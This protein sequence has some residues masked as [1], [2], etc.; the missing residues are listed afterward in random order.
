[1]KILEFG[2]GMGRL[3]KNLADYH[4]SEN[5]YGTDISPT[6]I[7]HSQNHLSGTNV[8]TSVINKDGS[9]PY[10]DEQ[11]DRI[12]SYA[13][14]QHISKK[15]VVQKSIAEISRTLKVGG[16]VKI[17]FWMISNPFFERRLNTD[18][19]AFE[20]KSLI[21]GWTTKFTVPLYRISFWRSNE[22]GGIR[23]GYRQLIKEFQ[24]NKIEIYGITREYPQFGYVW[25]YGEKIE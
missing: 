20:T 10:D 22:W 6:M 16:K 21:Y 14:I 19:F 15:S 1:M 24:K 7:K 8:S 18:A 9:L 3:I 25:L 11:F 5:I 13:V 23:L 2:C 17:Q 12:Y 4:P